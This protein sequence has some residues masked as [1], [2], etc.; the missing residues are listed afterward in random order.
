MPLRARLSLPRLAAAP[1]STRTFASSARTM[2]SADSKT[3]ASGLTPTE[4]KQLRERQPNDD[5]KSVLQGIRDVSGHRE[6][7]CRDQR[8]PA[9]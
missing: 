3:N 6:G 5:E 7:T 9:S 1:Q 4:S 2:T 8:L